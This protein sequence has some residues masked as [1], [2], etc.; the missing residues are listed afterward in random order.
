[1]RVTSAACCGLSTFFLQSNVLVIWVLHV[2]PD[3]LL[4]SIIGHPVDFYQHQLYILALHP[5]CFAHWEIWGN[6]KKKEK[7]KKG[8]CPRGLSDYK[9][10]HTSD[11][12]TRTT[13]LLFFAARAMI[14]SETRHRH[15]A[16]APE[17]DQSQSVFHLGIKYWLRVHW[18]HT[19]LRLKQPLPIVA[20]EML[21]YY[22]GKLQ[23]LCIYVATTITNTD[24][25]TWLARAPSADS[26]SFCLMAMYI[27]TQ[28]TY[29]VFNKLPPFII[30]VDF[31]HSDWVR[32]IV[33]SLQLVWCCCYRGH[34]Q[35]FS[36]YDHLNS[37]DDI[38]LYTT[39]GR[40]EAT[41]GR[42]YVSPNLQ[43]FEGF[44]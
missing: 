4:N 25:S 41:N 5:D 3:L 20:A 33:L 22:W 35:G 14:S 9:K 36:P 12:W 26:L 16:F 32:L 40:F 2:L 11:S 37:R 30:T 18:I 19:N 6:R 43:I 27:C 13:G 15:L 1:M 28:Q 8:K 39:H 34:S 42:P 24:R 29:V 38:P 31:K 23:I 21:L 17:L 44:T 7:K 10:H